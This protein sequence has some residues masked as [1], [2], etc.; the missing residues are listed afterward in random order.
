MASSGQDEPAGSS[1]VAPSSFENVILD[2]AFDDTAPIFRG[3][4]EDDHLDQQVQ[5]EQ[6][7]QQDQVR[8]QEPQQG[9]QAQR[10][11][12]TPTVTSSGQDPGPSVS[13]MNTPERQGQVQLP[14]ES[15]NHPNANGPPRNARIQRALARP[16]PVDEDD[17]AWA[18][19]NANRRAHQ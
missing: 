8:V 3:V 16:P 12:N 15:W 2:E 17:Q 6:Q 4:D 11:T 5:Q 18:T 7:P 14:P 13:Q 19:W 10:A 1:G 9:Q